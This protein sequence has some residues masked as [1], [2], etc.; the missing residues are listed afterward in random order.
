M[1]KSTTKIVVKTITKHSGIG[2]HCNSPPV[3]SLLPAG[4]NIAPYVQQPQ[5]FWGNDIEKKYK[6]IYQNNE[7]V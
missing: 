1:Y 6:T 5:E 2:F 4:T 3:E 7:Y